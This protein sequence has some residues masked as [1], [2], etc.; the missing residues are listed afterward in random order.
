MFSKI[1]IKMYL[2]R[3]LFKMLGSRA[4]IPLSHLVEIWANGHVISQSTKFKSH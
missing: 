4:L 2:R 3:L 1:K